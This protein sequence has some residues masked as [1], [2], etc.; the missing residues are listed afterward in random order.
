M[1][2]CSLFLALI[3]REKQQARTRASGAVLES[4]RETSQTTCVLLAAEPQAQG[5]K[6]LQFGSLVFSLL[7]GS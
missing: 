2:D 5:L 6:Y 3:K 1:L 7:V 4:S